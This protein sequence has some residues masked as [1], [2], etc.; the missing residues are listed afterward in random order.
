MEV[1]RGKGLRQGPSLSP[2][3]MNVYL[4]HFLD[5]PWRRL[6]PT[7][8]LLRYMDDLLVPCR[9]D[10]V[11]RTIHADL[12][13][14]ATNAG[15]GLKFD[16]ATAV[17]NLGKGETTDW[18]GFCISGNHEGIQPRLK[19]GDG[20]GDLPERLRDHLMKQHGYAESPQGAV[21]VIAGTIAQMGPAY[22]HNDH[23]Q[24]YSILR[25]AACDLAFEEI[26]SFSEFGVLWGKAYARWERRREIVFRDFDD[27]IEETNTIVAVG[28]NSKTPSTAHCR[29]KVQA[30]AAV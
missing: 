30:G 1:S 17:R 19:L 8:P 21:R 5:K 13:K 23:R 18:L 14:T 12:R 4:D 27:E 22:L 6:H 24:V 15:L 26:P 16:A 11:A 20:P 2:L 3:L 7:I 10:E 9:P 28:A 29:I 25:K